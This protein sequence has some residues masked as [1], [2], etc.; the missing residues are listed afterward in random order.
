MATL[1]DAAGLLQGEDGRIAD[2]L[3]IAGHDLVFTVRSQVLRGRA[4]RFGKDARPLHG[5]PE[6]VPWRNGLLPHRP[7]GLQSSDDQI[8]EPP[9]LTRKQRTG[10]TSRRHLASETFSTDKVNVG[11]WPAAYVGSLVVTVTSM[12]RSSHSGAVGS[13]DWV[14]VGLVLVVWV[15]EGVSVALGSG[16]APDG[17]A[18]PGSRTNIHQ[19]TSAMMTTRASSSS[20]RNQ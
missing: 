13:L 10:P 4:A 18:S 9:E 20:R 16:C 14:L 8:F 2:D 1:S 3:Q 19:A 6:T 11:C 17:S 15:G 5:L 7:T 12:S